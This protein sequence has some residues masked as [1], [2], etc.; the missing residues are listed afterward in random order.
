[1]LPQTDCNTAEVSIM[2]QFTD[3]VTGATVYINPD[4]VMSIRPDP[5]EPDTASIVKIRDGETIHV[6]GSHADVARKLLRRAA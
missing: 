5:A 6:H 2:V 3:R 1:L 4:Y